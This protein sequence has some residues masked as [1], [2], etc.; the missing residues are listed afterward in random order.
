MQ[1]KTG[2]LQK[3]CVLFPLRR[4]SGHHRRSKKYE[5]G[6]IDLFAVYCPDSDRIYLMR[7]ETKLNQGRLRV[8][9]TKSN[10]QQK[11][12]W[13]DKFEFEVFLGNLRKDLVELVG[14]EPTT[15][16]LPAQRSSN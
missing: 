8:E 7:S 9:Q 11:I 5:R 12:C 6:E 10:Q 16:A 3:G 15:F 13:S 1:V 2:L 4:F 14:L